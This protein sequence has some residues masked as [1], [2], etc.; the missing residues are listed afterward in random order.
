MEMVDTE[1]LVKNVALKFKVFSERFGTKTPR[2]KACQPDASTS[3]GLCRCAGPLI[4]V[5]FSKPQSF[6]AAWWIMVT[7]IQYFTVFSYL[8]FIKNSCDSF[9]P[10]MRKVT[11]RPFL[12]RTRHFLG[13]RTFSAKAG[14]APGEP[15]TLDYRPV[16]LNPL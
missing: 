16:V 3:V 1:L 7:Y 14:K 2:T 10:L 8:M 15:V 12:P 9:Y 4:V 11:N 5:V 6:F 13:H